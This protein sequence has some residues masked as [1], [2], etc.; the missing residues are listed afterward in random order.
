MSVHSVR[1]AAE[2]MGVPFKLAAWARC[3]YIKEQL[4]QQASDWKLFEDFIHSGEPWS[5]ETVA[6][7]VRMMDQGGLVSAGRE[8]QALT[9]L[10]NGH[11]SKQQRITDEQIEA[12][13]VFPIEQVIHFER[14]LALAPCHADKSPSLHWNRKH[15]KAH[16]FV[17]GKSFSALDFLIEF[18]G[19]KFVDAVLQLAT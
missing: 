17:C 10:I 8:L 14:G 5:A 3:R 1:K 7:D 19:L 15:N 11:V 12:A 2:E 13:R 4:R 16:C 6:I 18:Q 9:R